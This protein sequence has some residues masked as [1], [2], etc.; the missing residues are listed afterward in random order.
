VETY[1]NARETTRA[2]ARQAIHGETWA[3][4]IPTIQNAGVD[5]LEFSFDVE[6]GQAMWERLEEEKAIAQM[7]MQ[8]RKAE[9]VPDWLNAVVHPV[10]A[11]GGYRFLLETPTFSIKLL[12][13]VPNRPPIYVA[14]RAYGLHTHE[15]GAIGACEAACAFIRDTLLAD[16]APE[17]T[18]K[19]INLDTGRCSRLDL[20]LDWQGGWHPTFENG[21]ERAFIKRV[22]ADVGRYSVNGQVNGYEIGKSAVRGRIYNKTVQAKKKHVEWYPKLLQERNGDRYD[23]E[24]DVWRLEFQLRREG[25]KGFR[26]YARP[27]ASDPDDVIDAEIEAEDLP[28]IHSVRK[29]LH[30]AGH[31]WGYL[32][33]L[34]LRLTIPTDDPNRGR[35]PEHPTWAALRDGFAPLA[36][37]DAPLPERGLELVRAA[38]YTGYRRLLDRMAV[39]VATTLEAMDT[40]PGAALVSYV[41]YL[42]RIAGRIKRQQNRRAKAWRKAEQ[43]ATQMGIHIPLTP[44]VRQGLGARLDTPTRAQKRQQLL[45]MALGVFTSAG[46]AHL[47][48]QREADVSNLGDLLLYSLDELEAIAAEKGGVRQLLDEKWRKVYKANAPRRLFTCDEAPKTHAA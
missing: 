47:R 26:L 14:M 39:G 24:Q 5:T 20:F 10:G 25:V 22:H 2:L 38:R 36:L 41:A 13:G 32:T 12:K 9:H 31:L 11:K 34:W 30:W 4:W 28:H 33:K 1:E 46:V 16:E 15:S 27:D 29:A 6:I 8:T 44:D 35:W 40:D 3:E 7:L 21:D 18:A 19:V 48:M 43:E 23:Q 37:R 17:W 45:H 42:T